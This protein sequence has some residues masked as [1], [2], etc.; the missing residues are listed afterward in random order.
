MSEAAGLH[1]GGWR[2]Q[3]LGLILLL[4]SD[5]VQ[6]GQT[7]LE[8]QGH[9]HYVGQASRS[10]HGEWRRVDLEGTPSTGSVCKSITQTKSAFCQDGRGDED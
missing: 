8:A 10:K 1:G 7:Q 6:L 5:V 4:A 9:G 3:Y 2:E